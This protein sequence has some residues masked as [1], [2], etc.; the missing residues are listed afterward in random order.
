MLV[1]RSNEVN[2]HHLKLQFAAVAVVASVV[3][4]NG[5]AVAAAAADVAI[6]DN[7]NFDRQHSYRCARLCSWMLLHHNLIDMYDL[8]LMGMM[9]V[10]DDD[11]DDEMDFVHKSFPFD[12][13]VFVTVAVVVNVNVTIVFC[14][15]LWYDF[16]LF[17]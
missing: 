12:L 10:W 7:D 15:L 13:I 2:Y 6:V 5:D 17:F 8:Y 4:D 1:S 16:F 11:D 3:A 14:C 9:I